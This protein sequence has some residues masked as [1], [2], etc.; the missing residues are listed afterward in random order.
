MATLPSALSVSKNAQTS[1][2]DFAV[3]NP[4][5][6]TGTVSET[7]IADDAVSPA[8]VNLQAVAIDDGLTT[9]SCSCMSLTMA[10]KISPSKYYIRIL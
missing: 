6:D 2:D 9:L 3:N 8:N 5:T 10:I 4:V 7:A 1:L